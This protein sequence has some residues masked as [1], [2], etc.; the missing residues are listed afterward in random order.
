M[1]APEIDLQ[2]LFRLID[3][4]GVLAN[5]IL[6]GMAARAARLD[7]VGFSIL[8]VISG[9]GG[10]MMR[11]ALLNR[12]AVAAL[13]DPLYLVVAILGAALI[14]FMPMDGKVPRR[15]VVLLDALA[16]GCWAN[17][18]SQKGIAAGLG[19]L[20]VIFLGMTT[21]IGGGMV[22]D[23]L[24]MRVPTVF[25]GNTLYATCALVS[26]L[27]TYVANVLHMPE[28]GAALAILVGAGLSLLARRLGWAL[29]VGG[30]RIELPLRSRRDN[31]TE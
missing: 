16:L 14:W 20:A 3:L 12:G 1:A 19:V 10:G 11:D 24:L 15:T 27:I 18:G 31:A 26:C 21:A 2:E 22:R 28:V 9:L 30:G 29:P 23:V 13:V 8:A 4:A 7:F 6:G 25:G 5:A 17:V